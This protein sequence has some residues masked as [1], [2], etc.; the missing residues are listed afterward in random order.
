M[1]NANSKFMLFGFEEVT[2]VCVDIRSSLGGSTPS[3]IKRI[4]ERLLGD[5]Y[6]SNVVIYIG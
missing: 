3:F 4:S 5:A 1:S 6:V 2:D